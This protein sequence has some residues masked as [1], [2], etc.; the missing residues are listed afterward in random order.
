MTRQSLGKMYW[1]RRVLY[2]LKQWQ[3][4]ICQS[5]ANQNDKVILFSREGR[6]LN[7]FKKQ[8]QWSDLFEYS[9]KQS[10]ENMHCS[11]MQHLLLRETSM[12]RER[13]REEYKACIHAWLTLINHCNACINRCI[14][15]ISY[16]VGCK[17]T[18]RYP[19]HYNKMVQNIIL[20]T[21]Q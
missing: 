18:F 8:I 21:Y 14:A 9:K 20:C 10:F 7:C 19:L 13:G 12:Y 1:K 11:M 2:S 3:K 16:L 15:C 6:W 17:K 5:I 4:F